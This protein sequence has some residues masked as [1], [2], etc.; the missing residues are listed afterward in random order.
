MPKKCDDMVFCFYLMAPK[1]SLGSKIEEGGMQNSFTGEN[2]YF[3]YRVNNDWHKED[4][5][6]KGWSFIKK[7]KQSGSILFKFLVLIFICLGI[8]FIA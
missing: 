3:D 8:F 2:S 4:K 1:W 6:C 7:S 5:S